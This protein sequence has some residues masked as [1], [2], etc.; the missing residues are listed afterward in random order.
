M[1]RY[2]G[3][4]HTHTTCSDGVRSPEE[5]IAAYREAGYDFLAIT[6]HRLYTPGE[7]LPGFTLR[8]D[9]TGL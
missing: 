4:L 8:R 2:K 1:P 6:D 9:G 7:E 3:N 5:A